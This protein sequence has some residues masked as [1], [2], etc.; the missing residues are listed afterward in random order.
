[1]E[2]TVYFNSNFARD[3]VTRRSVTGTI[4]Y[5]GNCPVAWLSKRQGAIATGTYGAELCVAKQGTEDDIA[6]GG[7]LRSFGAPLK[8]RMKLLGDN[9]GLRI[10]VTTPGSTCKKKQSSIAYHFGRECNAAGIVEVL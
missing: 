8:G 2:T 10:S 9:L 5:V 4:T 6:I 1:L 3:E 7:I